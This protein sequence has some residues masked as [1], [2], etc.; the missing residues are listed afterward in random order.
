MSHKV[1]TIID[2]ETFSEKKQEACRKLG[3]TH[4]EEKKCRNLLM[5]CQESVSGK[6]SYQ[7]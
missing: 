5:I 2:Y 6:E 4:A 3:E 1:A 7:S